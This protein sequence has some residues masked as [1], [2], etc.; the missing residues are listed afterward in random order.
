MAKSLLC[1]ICF[2]ELVSLGHAQHSPTPV[3][4]KVSSSAEAT[5]NFQNPGKGTI[6]ALNSD[7]VLGPGDQV[8]IIVPDLDDLFTTDKIFRIDGSGDLILP[9]VG[10]LHAA[11]IT[12]EAL[13]KEIEAA[14]TGKILKRPQAVVNIIEY[15]SQPV[16]VLG[17]VNAPGLHQLVGEKNLFEALSQAGGFTDNLGNTIRIT[18]DLKWGP[19][20]L[21]GA[22]DDATGQFSVASLNVRN[23]LKA[24]DPAH[25]NIALMPDDVISVSRTE[26]VYAVG[27]VTKP[28]GFQ[29]GQDET[30][31]TLQVLSLAEGLDKV[32]APERA[33]ILRVVP[34]SAAK[35]RIPVNVKQVMAGNGQDMPLQADDI[36]FIPSSKVKTVSY[37]TLEAAV[38]AVT[39][40][41]IYGRF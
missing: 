38:T 41:A 28:G 16:S 4:P 8:S 14:L 29:L 2:V 5:G 23:V 7:Y 39:G 6:P 27:S 31:T 10:R 22:R 40:M 18:R 1:T 24:S 33:L 32:A 20:P 36:L 3:D 11:G 19:I 35:I 17:E 34:G 26:V 30:L 21:P 25:Q 12:S 9:Y 13:G 15:H 37:R